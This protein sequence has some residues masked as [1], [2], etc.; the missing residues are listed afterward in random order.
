MHLSNDNNTWVISTCLTRNLKIS[1]FSHTLSTWSAFQNFWK[2]CFTDRLDA[3][4]CLVLESANFMVN[5]LSLYWTQKPCFKDEWMHKN[6]EVGIS[7]IILNLLKTKPARLMGYQWSWHSF[8]Y[9]SINWGFYSIKL[10]YLPF[11]ITVWQYDD[12]NKI[13][14]LF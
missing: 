3:K 6:T 4:H 7:S 2:L 11:F 9:T 12:W 5:K 8:V 13:L 1:N 10:K 14:W